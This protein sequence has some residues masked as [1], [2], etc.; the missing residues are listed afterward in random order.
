MTASDA[1]RTFRRFRV[2]AWIFRFVRPIFAK[3]DIHYRGDRPSSGPMIF[4]ANHNSFF[5]IPVGLEFFLRLG[6]APQIA[7]HRRF[8]SNRIVG[9][10]LRY[11]GAVP[12][13]AGTGDQW[14]A[15]AVAELDAGRAVALMPEGRITEENTTVGRLRS[16][17]VR[18]AAQTDAPV[19][20]IG[21][22]GTDEVWP[23]GRPIPR[24]RI[25]RPTIV[26]NVGVPMT[27]DGTT[28]DAFIDELAAAVDELIGDHATRPAR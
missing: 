20:P 19:W 15:G 5:D 18:L 21:V 9:A 10:A 28:P 8:F 6:I 1:R 16:G 4:V 24:L 12:V 25:R 13:E 22:L 23:L 17:V 11:V 3:V 2:V 14:L 27:T 26:V 7:V